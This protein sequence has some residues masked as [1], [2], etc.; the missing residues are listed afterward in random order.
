MKA[1]PTIWLAFIENRRCLIITKCLIP[2]SYN[3]T[4]LTE[5]TLIT[6]GFLQNV[7]G[8]GREN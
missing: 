2:R 5:L 6:F 7:G 4:E 3:R 8:R 1:S